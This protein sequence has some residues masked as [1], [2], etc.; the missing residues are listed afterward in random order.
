VDVEIDQARADATVRLLLEQQT[1]AA[2]A[3]LLELLADEPVQIWTDD[4]RAEWWTFTV[5]G[6]AFGRVHRS[7]V[8]TVPPRD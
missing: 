1:P 3:A 4:G 2:R 8:E 7:R 5:D 6:V